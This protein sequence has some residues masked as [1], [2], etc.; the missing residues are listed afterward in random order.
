MSISQWQNA[1]AVKSETVSQYR[2]TINVNDKFTDL[3]MCVFVLS[4]T[5]W[6]PAL[7]CLER[8]SATFKVS[9][10]FLGLICCTVR[11]EH[12]D[13]MT[14]FVGNSHNKLQ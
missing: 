12:V 9:W 5:D 4:L 1:E 8:W 2:G 10:M 14:E 11:S 3:C 6:L 13:H 7:Q